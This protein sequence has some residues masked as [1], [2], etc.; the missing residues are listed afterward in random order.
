MPSSSPLTTIHQPNRS[1]TSPMMDMELRGNLSHMVDRFSS[2]DER[3]LSGVA[4]AFYGD[5]GATSHMFNKPIVTSASALPMPMQY[6]GRPTNVVSYNRPQQ[7]Q[8]Q[9]Q[10]AVETDLQDKKGNK[11]KKASKTGSERF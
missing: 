1:Y 9:Q 5:K 4:S 11:R 3:L 8:T 2:P 7:Q 10:A 6:G